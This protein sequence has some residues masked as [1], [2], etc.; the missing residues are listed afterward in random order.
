M[1]SR[2]YKSD[3][4]LQKNSTRNI[5]FKNLKTNC[6][7]DAGHQFE[8]LQKENIA[9]DMIGTSVVQEPKAKFKEQK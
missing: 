2:W 9:N 1:P 6:L 8:P 7:V 3:D 4:G 5:I